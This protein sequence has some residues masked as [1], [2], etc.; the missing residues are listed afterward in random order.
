MTS[1]SALTQVGKV[2][3]QWMSMFLAVLFLL[4]ATPSAATPLTDALD[5]Y[6]SNKP[7]QGPM[8]GSVLV[9]QGS[10]IL[11]QKAYGIGDKQLGT[12]GDI[13]SEYR[14][15]SMSKFITAIAVARAVQQG[16]ISS[17]QDLVS[18]YTIVPPAYADLKISD[19]LKHIG[20]VTNCAGTWELGWALGVEATFQQ[21]RANV[22]S[23]TRCNTGN[24]DYRDMNFFIAG[25]VV[26]EAVNP[27]APGTA[28]YQDYY[29]YVQNQIFT[30][31][32]MTS[33]KYV[34]TLGYQSPTFA[35]LHAWGSTYQE[36][37]MYYPASDVGSNTHWQ[38]GGTYGGFRM[39][40]ADYYKLLRDVFVNHTMISAATS[41]LLIADTTPVPDPPAFAPYSYSS[42]ADTYGY[43]IHLSQIDG[44]TVYYHLGIYIPTQQSS[45]F[46]Y[47]P[48][49]DVT[50]VV[51]KNVGHDFSGLHDSTE[52][53][54]KLQEIYFANAAGY[55]DNLSF[56][57]SASYSGNLGGLAGA[58]QKCTT[59]AHAAGLRTNA[60]WRA[61]L[62]AGNTVNENVPY[63]AV[64]RITL[65]G[66][67]KNK[68][69]PAET[70]ANFTT[71]LWSPSLLA[72]NKYNQNG[73]DVGSAPIW[74][75]S[76]AQGKLLSTYRD[77]ADWTQANTNTADIGYPGYLDFNR[78]DYYWSDRYCNGQAR[79]Y[80]IS[81]TVT[82]P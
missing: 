54:T 29:D 4:S 74:T 21:M 80:C 33:A 53:A 45:I 52:I 51:L 70:I 24:Y 75:A 48:D 82:W 5:Y 18:T 62:S 2:K 20:G 13:N 61:I 30:P 22:F 56:V 49:Q 60:R 3:T 32:G 1:R 26:A 42:G 11:F 65:Y 43:G 41:Q 19:V 46:M 17:M 36:S 44:R 35:H 66:P 37:D 16:Y 58:D 77:C 63:D 67:V 27:G 64:R 8:H 6:V 40:P 34:M 72:P 73:V 9:A 81:Q 14:V 68:K 39:S 57:T 10:N 59:A 55:T 69:V 12:R 38:V 25:L 23:N 50:V 79:L 31:L 78:M 28:T 7:Q 47:F 76:S 15:A 71:S